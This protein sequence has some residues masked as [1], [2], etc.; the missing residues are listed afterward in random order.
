M[1]AMEK[2]VLKLAFTKYTEFDG[3]TWS[4]FIELYSLWKVTFERRNLLEAVTQKLIQIL[5]LPATKS[6]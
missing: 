5:I 2:W 1:Q 6:I 3:S 4:L